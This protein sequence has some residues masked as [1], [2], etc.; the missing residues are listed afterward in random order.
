MG[1]A[2]ILETDLHKLPTHPEARQR[3]RRLIAAGDEQVKLRRRMVKTDHRR[4]VDERV[5][6]EV[7]IVQHQQDTMEE[8]GQIVNERGDEMF[9]L[10]WLQK[11]EHGLR[12]LADMGRD[13]LYRA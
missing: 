6:D 3:Q 10:K 2:Q 13:S 9:E 1:E 8:V 7:V 12:R 11:V 5:A 4:L